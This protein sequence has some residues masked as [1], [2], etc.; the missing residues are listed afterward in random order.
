MAAL[1]ITHVNVTNEEEYGKYVKLAGPALEKY[2][3]KFLARGTRYKWMEGNERPRNVVLR[4]DSIEAA[5]AC[6][7]SPEYQHA[8]SFAEGAAERDMVFV[9]IIED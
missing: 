7:N 6:Y 3:A 8:L 1:W 2:G 4:F 9:E 5:E